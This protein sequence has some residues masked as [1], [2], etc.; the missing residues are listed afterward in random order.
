MCA[1][2]TAW[3]QTSALLLLLEVPSQYAAPPKRFLGIFLNMSISLLDT[4]NFL[5]PNPYPP[6]PIP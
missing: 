6:Y 5:F 3:D 1:G 4:Y 2:N